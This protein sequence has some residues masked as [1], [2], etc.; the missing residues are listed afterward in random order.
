MKK[1]KICGKPLP[2]NS[3]PNVCFGECMQISLYGSIENANKATINS[4]A[5]IGIK[6]NTNNNNNNQDESI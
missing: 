2:E 1:C 4:F 3:K 5:K 6:I